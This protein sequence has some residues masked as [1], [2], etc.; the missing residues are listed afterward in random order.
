VDVPGVVGSFYKSLDS[1]ARFFFVNNNFVN[2]LPFFFFGAYIAVKNPRFD[3]AGLFAV[4]LVAVI[5]SSSWKAHFPDPIFITGF[6]VASLFLILKDTN[7]SNPR[8][9]NFLS[10]I[11]YSFYLIH[12]PV[13][14]SVARLVEKREMVVILSIAITVTLAY[15]SHRFIEQPFIRMAKRRTEKVVPK[16]VAI[17]PTS[18]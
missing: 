3:K 14:V 2:Q 11:S 13:I 7:Y 4:F 18:P 15:L 17:K 9:V 1:V 5:L 8:F 16:E 12:Y 10:D 6:G